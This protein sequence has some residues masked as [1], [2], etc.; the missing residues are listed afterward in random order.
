MYIYTY[1][2]MCV[3]IYVYIC[4]YIYVCVYI[5]THTHTHTQD[6]SC[7]DLL[8]CVLMTCF[9]STHSGLGSLLGAGAMA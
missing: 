2:Y 3:C 1:V 5:Y 4:M 7:L 8:P 6:T 9:L